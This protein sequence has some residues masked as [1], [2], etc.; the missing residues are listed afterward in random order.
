MEYDIFFLLIKVVCLFIF[1]FLFFFLGRVNET[2]CLV[3][4]G[5]N[6]YDEKFACN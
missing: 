2:K 4:S 3:E 6:H 1:L 5:T